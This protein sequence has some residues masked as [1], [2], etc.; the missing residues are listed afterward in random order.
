VAWL[1][2]HPRFHMH[3]TPTYVNIHLGV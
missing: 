3:Y 1:D 2:K